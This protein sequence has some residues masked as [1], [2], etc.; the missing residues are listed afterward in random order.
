MKSFIF[1]LALSFMSCRSQIVTNSCIFNE[2]SHAITDLKLYTSDFS[3]LN[4]DISLTPGKKRYYQILMPESP[5]ADG[6]YILTFEQDGRRKSHRFGYYTNGAPLMD[7]E[8]FI[9]NDTIEI[10]EKSL[11]N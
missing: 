5:K 2:S 7:F 3:V 9:Y 4:K 8:I 6:S 10:K 1:I 11:Y